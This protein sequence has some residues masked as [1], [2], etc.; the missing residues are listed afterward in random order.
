M[1]SGWNT[2]CEKNQVASLS[3]DGL[4]LEVAMTTRALLDVNKLYSANTVLAE[5]YKTLKNGSEHAAKIATRDALYKNHYEEGVPIPWK[6]SIA[7]PEQCAAITTI[8]GVESV[9]ENP[10]VVS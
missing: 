3:E 1:L 9:E 2:N 7:L 4:T 5:T 10:E 8:E 6:A